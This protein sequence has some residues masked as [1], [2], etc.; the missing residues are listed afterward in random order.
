MEVWLLLKIQFGIRLDLANSDRKEVWK[1]GA[2]GKI[3]MCTSYNSP[4]KATIVF[5]K[6]LK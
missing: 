2:G 6:S 4:S 5:L 1:G 3:T